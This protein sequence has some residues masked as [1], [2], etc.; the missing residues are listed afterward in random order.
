M[1]E[2]KISLFYNEG[3][4]DKVY[5]V[6]LINSKITGD[7]HVNI[8]YGRRGNALTIGNK[9]STVDYN[10]AKKVYDKLV[11]EKTAKGYKSSSS[12]PTPIYKTGGIISTPE[13]TGIRPQLLNEVDEEDLEKY[14]TDDNWCAQE[15]FDGRRRLL[16]KQG[17]KVKGTNRKGLVVGITS[18][19]EKDLLKLD[20]PSVILD[21]EAFDDRVMIFDSLGENLPYKERYQKMLNLLNQYEEKS[22]I[23]VSTAWTTEDKREL[24]K[25]LRRCNAEG[26]VFK[27]I[28][29]TY[30]PGRPN[31]GGDQLKF[32][33]V[34]TASCIVGRINAG[35]RSVALTVYDSE[36][37]LVEIGNVT[38][39][40]NQNV[41]KLG[42]IV[43]VRYLYYFDKG[44]LFQP[45]LLGNGDCS[46]DDI[47]L[48]DCLLS[49]L[50]LKREEVLSE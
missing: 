39:Y 4:S 8:G 19:I 2:E 16:I 6:E 45:V 27:N 40:P 37:K 13:D 20:V 42:E 22:I 24:L 44:S 46:R 21:G 7:W 41:P 49:K 48:K 1:S 34:T 28:H 47:D 32:K 35:K 38:I 17:T 31:S 29:S 25:C 14:I 12:S 43:E 15:K 50:K 33:F 9:I 23:P 3:S 10:R 26:I 11:A 30:K 18:D 36:F 5:N